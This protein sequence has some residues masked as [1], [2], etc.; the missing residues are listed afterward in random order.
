MPY[1][2]HFFA[3]TMAIWWVATVQMLHGAIYTDAGENGQT[4]DLGL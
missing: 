4:Y 1:Y 2:N 3:K